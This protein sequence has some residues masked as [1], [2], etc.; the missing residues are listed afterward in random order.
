VPQVPHSSRQQ[1]QQ[2][3]GV[4]WGLCWVQQEEL[5]ED[6]FWEVPYQMRCLGEWG[7]TRGLKTKDGQGLLVC[8]S[9]RDMLAAMRMASRKAGGMQCGL[10]LNRCWRCVKDVPTDYTS[11]CA[12][13]C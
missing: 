2:G 9:L 13:S 8:C 5:W 7:G 4:C 3:V 1:H 6:L 10:L 12:A 11:S